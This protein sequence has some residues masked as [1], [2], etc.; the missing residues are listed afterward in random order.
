MTDCCCL[1]VHL[2]LCLVPPFPPVAIFLVSGC[3]CLCIVDLLLVLVSVGIPLFLSLLL[4]VAEWQVSI[5]A[6][7]G[8]SYF[9][10]RCIAVWAVWTRREAGRAY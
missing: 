6:G 9:L 7:F 10:A 5:G 8:I 1:V 3:S 2:A 4:N